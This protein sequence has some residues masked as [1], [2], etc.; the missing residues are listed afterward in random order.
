MQVLNHKEIKERFSFYFEDEN[1][2]HYICNCGQ[3]FER[4]VEKEDG[5]KKE[6]TITHSDDYAYLYKMIEIAQQDEIKCPGCGKNFL[7]KEQHQFLMLTGRFFVGG[8]NYK[9][10][11]KNIKLEYAE[12][13]PVKSEVIIPDKDTHY[14]IEF[15]EKSKYIRFEKESRKLFFKNYTEE[16]IE[17]DLDEVIKTVDLFFTQGVEIIHNL[18]YLHT[19][20]WDLS[21]CVSDAGNIDI[22]NGLLGEIRNQFGDGGTDKIKKII[23]IFFGIIKYSNLSTL[24][25]TKDATFLFDMMRDCDIPKPQ[26]LIDNKV[27]SPIKIFNFLIKNYIGKINDEI[28]EDNQEAHEFVFKSS[29]K[30]ERELVLD[31]E[32]NVQYRKDGSEID[33]LHVMDD[34]VEQEMQVKYKTHDGYKPKVKKSSGKFEV[35]SAAE[36][37]SISKFIFKAVR[38]FSDY[39]QIMRYFKFFDKQQVISLLQK[40]DIDFLVVFIDIIYFRDI[41]DMKEFERIARI[42]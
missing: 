6:D 22:V 21:K 27:T 26:V 35:V 11:D 30:M 3:Y 42:V 31:E 29:V 12:A 25:L 34:G 17:F 36:D 18:Y 39:K 33:V 40:Y 37:G 32:G 2:N 23:S 14:E 4:D 15:Q 28:N 5:D 1:K 20:L 41:E 16:E 8:Y 9:E 19:F 10:D 24:A 7:S 38:R 13:K